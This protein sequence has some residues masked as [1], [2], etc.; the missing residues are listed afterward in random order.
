M[1]ILIQM[2]FQ[3]L[4]SIQRESMNDFIM[5]AKLNAN[6]TWMILGGGGS[7]KRWKEIW[8]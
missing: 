8:A 4:D 7:A 2:G 5:I 3:F 1:I 6:I